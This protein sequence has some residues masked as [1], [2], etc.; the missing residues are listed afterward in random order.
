MTQRFV[1]ASVRFMHQQHNLLATRFARQ[2]PPPIPPVTVW[3]VEYC[4]NVA[5]ALLQIDFLHLDPPGEAEAGDAVWA[6]LTAG[7]VET[8]VRM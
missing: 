1:R 5:H 3:P 2:Y 8:R 4:V 6:A 7:W